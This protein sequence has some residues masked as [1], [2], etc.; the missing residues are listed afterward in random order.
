[1]AFI[2]F[3]PR[4]QK[5]IEIFGGDI[6]FD[7]DGKNVGILSRSEQ[8]YELSPGQHSI[9]M[10]KSHTYDT[11]IG[12]AETSI[13]VDENE[14]LMVKYSAPMMINQPGNMIISKYDAHYRDTVLNER[15]HI[16]ERD[17]KAEED[18]KREANEKYNNGIKWVII[19]VIIF[20]IIFGIYEGILWSSIY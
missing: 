13:T 20:A 8:R 18:R 11:Y 1:M 5:E 15:E 7:I 4:T 14:E 6:Y 9:K 10:Y 12:F 19:A 16:L 3:L 2:V 17:F